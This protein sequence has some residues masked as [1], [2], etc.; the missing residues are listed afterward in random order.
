MTRSLNDGARSFLEVMYRGCAIVGLEYLAGA[1]QQKVSCYHADG[2]ATQVFLARRLF[3][4][5]E[6]N[7]LVGQ[8]STCRTVYTTPIQQGRSWAVKIMNWLCGR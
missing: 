8:C 3:L 6:G 1:K 2:E 5:D 7:F 4:G